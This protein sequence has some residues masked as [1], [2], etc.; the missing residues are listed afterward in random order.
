M[1]NKLWISRGVKLINIKYFWIALILLIVSS[2]IAIQFPHAV[3]FGETIMTAL[4][5]P[6]QPMNGL[7]Y[8]GIT[9][10]VLFIVSVF[11]LTR[12]LEKYHKRAVFLWLLVTIYA[13][14][15][16]VN[17]YQETFATGIYAVSYDWDSSTCDF[18]M[19]GEFNMDG[20][21]ELVFENKSED[22]VY[23]TVTFY[24]KNWYKDEFPV[25]SLMNDKSPF[26]VRLPGNETKI[27][28]LRKMIEGF[29]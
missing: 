28:K 17:L 19:I 18:G 25:V 22:E 12:S 21:C 5:F 6:P 11:F 29:W 4:N 16:V 26:E 14:A 7:Q 27:V 10:L 8:V 9:S 24:E 3:P 20:E 13:P 2:A 1:A 23:F 15:I